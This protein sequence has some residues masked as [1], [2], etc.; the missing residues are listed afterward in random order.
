M[1]AT[2]QP[3]LFSRPSIATKVVAMLV[4]LALGGLAAFALFAPPTRVSQSGSTQATR[5]ITVPAPA[6]ESEGSDRGLPGG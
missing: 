3:P 5:T 2:R 6:G 4:V 1:S